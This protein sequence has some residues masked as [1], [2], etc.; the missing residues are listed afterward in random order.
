LKAAVFS[1]YLAKCKE[2]NNKVF[3]GYIDLLRAKTLINQVKLE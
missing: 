3:E 2:Q 1:N